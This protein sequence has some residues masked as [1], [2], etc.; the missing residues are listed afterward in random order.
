MIPQVDG[1]MDFRALI[2]PKKG[3]LYERHFF[4]M[5]TQKKSST[6]WANPTG[7]GFGRKMTEMD[8]LIDALDRYVRAVI[9]YEK[10]A[11]GEWGPGSSTVTERSLATSELEEKL[12]EYVVKRIVDVVRNHEHYFNDP[13]WPYDVEWFK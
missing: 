1:N 2:F 3:K 8:E 10:S 5:A 13:K 6:K 4:A 7:V 12:D 9:D 11:L